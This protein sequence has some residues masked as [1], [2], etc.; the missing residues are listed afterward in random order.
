[1][2]RHAILVLLIALMSTAH[3]QLEVSLNLK[4]NM[5]IRGEPLEATVVIRNLAGK[6]V[7]LTDTEGE[8]WFGFEIMKGEGNLIA[9][10]S[11]EYKNAPQVLLS[12][13]TMRRTVDLVRLFPVNEYGTYTVRAA[14]YFQEAGKY[15][16]SA[17]VK[18]DISEGRK[19]WSQTVGVPASKDGA[20]DYHVV[21]LLTF[22]H[23]KQMMLYVRIVDEKTGTIFGTYPLGRYLGGGELGHEFDRDNTLHVLH[24]VGPSQYYLSKIG[25]NGEWYPQTM[26]ESAKGRPLVRK[27]EDGRMVIV[28]A[29]RSAEKLPAGPEVP[30]LSDRPVTLPK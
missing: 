29:T 13:A 16:A 23:P 1:M 22:P 28:G 2:N 24:M 15:I 30:R 3:A 12:G 17:P 21:S 19:L 6:D 10:H 9:P 26:W 5:F 14:I 18:L 4:R 25:V 7:M 27:K 20:G 8:R 11:G